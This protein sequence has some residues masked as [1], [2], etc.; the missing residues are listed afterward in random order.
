MVYTMRILLCL[1]TVVSI[2]D[3]ISTKHA[4]SVKNTDETKKNREFMGENTDKIFL[5]LENQHA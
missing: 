3:V 5:L 2:E 4:F 1:L